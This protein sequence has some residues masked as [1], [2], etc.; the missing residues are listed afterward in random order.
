MKRAALNLMRVAGAFAMFRMINRR[1]PLILTYHRFSETEDETSTSAAAFD[2]QLA[3]L[4]AHYRL[5]PL[6]SLIEQLNG[7]G[8]P[9]GTAAIT[10]DD[11]YRDSYEIAFPLLRHYGVPATVY[12]VT[13][14]TEGRIWL[15][16][17]KMRYLTSRA[18]SQEAT[19]TI[20]GAPVRIA[21]WDKRSRMAAAERLNT[22]LKRLD[23]Q[24]K[25]EAIV[26]VAATLGA[27]L[28]ETP[29]DEYAAID[30]RQAREM[31][32]NGVEI[33]SHTVTHPILTRIDD[34][35]LEWELKE[36]RARLEAR[37]KRRIEHFCYPNGDYD[38]RV[39]SAVAQ[40]GYDS[41]VT[42]VSGLNDAGED[43]LSL[44]RIH[45]ESDLVHFMQSTSGIEEMK[46]RLRSAG[47]RRTGARPFSGGGYKNPGEYR[48]AL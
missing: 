12:V 25:E 5:I 9:P 40:A 38:E 32:A 33:G 29:P 28:P 21:L 17:D 30:W 3:Y 36:S 31:D 2:Q 15:W 6:S 46:E 14:F 7:K 11:G 27:S 47:G 16:T 22:A 35:R 13:E 20:D 41:A 1:R 37:L 4:T 48:P 26:R 8:A 18:V 42:T 34:R 24:A 23:D 19:T 10:I 44:R 39:R 45:T 43:R